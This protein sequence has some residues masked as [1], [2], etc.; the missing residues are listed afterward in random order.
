MPALMIRRERIISLIRGESA[1]SEYDGHG[2]CYL[3]F[4]HDNVARVG[5]TFRSGQ[6]PTGTFDAPSRLL[7]AEKAQFGSSRVQRWFDRT[8]TNVPN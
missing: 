3:E 1:T 5:V 8:W 7:A 2:V 4:G 6:A